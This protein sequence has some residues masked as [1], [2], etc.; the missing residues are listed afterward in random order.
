[1]A[2]HIIRATED[3]IL[4]EVMKGQQ[5]IA[6]LFTD[7]WLIVTD[8]RVFILLPASRYIVEEEKEENE[9]RTS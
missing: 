9:D 4:F 6:K 3:A 5:A 8:D 7:E 2:A 1:M